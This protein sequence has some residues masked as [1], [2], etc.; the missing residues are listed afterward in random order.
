MTGAAIG[1]V[2]GVGVSYFGVPSLIFTLGT[3][4]VVRGLIYIMSGGR[5]IEKLRRRDF[6][7]R[8]QD[9]VRWA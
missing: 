6:Q 4:S 3:N 5:T 2:N 1:L 8:Q 7:L 9:R